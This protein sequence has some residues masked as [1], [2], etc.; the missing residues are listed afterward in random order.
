MIARVQILSQT[1]YYLPNWG[2][3]ALVIINVYMSDIPLQI[4]MHLQP[5]LTP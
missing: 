4:C 5:T 2:S 3:F 1:H